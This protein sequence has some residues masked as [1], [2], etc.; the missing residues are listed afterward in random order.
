MHGRR[1]KLFGWLLLAF[2]L[3]AL[4]VRTPCSAGDSAS[5]E[6]SLI[7]S[8]GSDTLPREEY[9]TWE[10][11]RSGVFYDDGFVLIGSESRAAPTSNFNLK[12]NFWGHLRHSYSDSGSSRRD[13]NQLQLKRGRVIF[14]G[15]AFVP[16]FTYFVQLDG[17]SAAGDNQ[18]LLDYYFRY[19]LGSG[20]LG[21]E[22]QK[23]GLLIGRYKMP[24]TLAR[25]LSGKEL[26]FSDRSMSS[27]FFDVNRSMAMGMYGT[28]DQF[29]KPV[30]WEFA[31][32]NG[33]ATGSASTGTN[34]TLDNNLAV[35]GR[36]FSNLL[37]EWE[38]GSLA[39]FTSHQGLA[40]R[41]GGGFAVSTIDRSGLTEFNRVRV[42]DSGQQLSSLIPNAVNQ[43]SVNLFSV[44]T[45]AK[46][47]GWSA[48][49]EY[50]FRN[51]GRFQGAA[52]DALFDHGFWLQAGRFLVED[53]LQ[54]LGRWS[55]VQ[56][57]S[58]SLGNQV[59]SAEE[60][61]GALVWYFN[62]QAAKL[63]TDLTYINGAP[64]ESSVLDIR[65]GEIGWLWRTQYQ[66][67]F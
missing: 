11:H 9:W 23:L 67:S 29:R 24:F 33:L 55:R 43:Y 21:L 51:V 44:D 19:D 47:R 1:K 31:L 3:S 38:E 14:S 66:F 54:A 26:E 18:R 59:R 25:W 42:V 61:S 13:L 6:I 34:G 57:D 12:L 27:I 37:G 8:A 22:R 15:N 17:R 5:T 2:A 48:T 62:R 50:Y 35:S 40:L 49:F 10:E 63:V 36:M 56:G 4:S 30:F 41:V 32:F 60:I 46:F 7:E 64:I 39:D 20:Q 45:S 52:I 53:N 58:G 16:E 28:I 65:A